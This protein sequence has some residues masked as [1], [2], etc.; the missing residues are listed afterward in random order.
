MPEN[1]QSH[2]EFYTIKQVALRTGLTPCQ[3]NRLD[4]LREIPAPIVMI[5]R[6]ACWS[7]AE[8]EQWISNGRPV[9]K[10]WHPSHRYRWQRRRRRGLG[11][12]A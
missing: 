7:P 8:V 10:D 12:K 4:Y 3:I 1:Q 11:T 9:R 2:P 5:G 6:T